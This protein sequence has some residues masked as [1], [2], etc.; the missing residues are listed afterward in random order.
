MLISRPSAEQTARFYTGLTEAIHC[1]HERQSRERR[2]RFG[3]GFFHDRCTVIFDS[4]PTEPE[5]SRDNFARFP[6][7][8]QIH[9][10]A[11]P[12]SEY[13]QTGAGRLAALGSLV[14]ASRKS[15]KDFA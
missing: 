13:I 5:I 14:D 9:D 10:L 7:Q 4:A 3:T 8:Y 15:L 2:D 11:L 12:R 1:R 6:S